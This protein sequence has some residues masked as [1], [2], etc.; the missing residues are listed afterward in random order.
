MI[1]SLVFR[2]GGKLP[3]AWRSLAGQL[4]GL[5]VAGLHYSLVIG[6]SAEDE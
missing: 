2:F 6:T 4:T 3:A 5:A 1:C